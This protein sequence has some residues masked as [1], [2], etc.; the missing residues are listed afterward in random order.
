MTD[1]GLGELANTMMAQPGRS[2]V[3]ALTAATTGNP[4]LSALDLRLPRLF[5]SVKLVDGWPATTAD[6]LAQGALELLGLEGTIDLVIADPHHTYE[7]TSAGVV[8]GLRLLRPGGVMLVHDCLPPPDLI[9]PEFQQGSWCGE[10]YA[11][12]RD[13]CRAQQLPWFTINAD[14][15]IGVVSQLVRNPPAAPA[16]EVPGHDPVKSR[17][18][19]LADPYTFMRA[20]TPS[21]AHVAIERMTIGDPVDDLVQVFRGWEHTDLRPGHLGTGVADRTGQLVDARTAIELLSRQ[22]EI[23]RREGVETAEGGKRN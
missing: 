14:F 23:L 17:R 7:A 16:L 1:W 4:A 9:E 5:V 8:A 2:R 13:V 15:G 6:E 18:A 19:Y 12:F 20:V 10:S 11:A 22:V 3:V 21:D